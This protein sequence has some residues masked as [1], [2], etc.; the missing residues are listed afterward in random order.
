[1]KTINAELKS[2]E[3]LIPLGEIEKG[4]TDMVVDKVEKQINYLNK[5]YS[6]AL[7]DVLKANLKAKQTELGE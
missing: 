7:N 4:V 1:M 2:E 6:T 3:I 5:I